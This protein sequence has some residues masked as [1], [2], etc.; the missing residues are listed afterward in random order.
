MSKQWIP[1]KQNGRDVRVQYSIPI[2]F[3]IG[4][5]KVF[6]TDL[7]NSPYGFVFEIDGTDYTIDEVK[8]IIGKS[9]PSE[10]IKAVETYYDTTKYAIGDKKAIYL[11]I[12]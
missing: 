1:G 11:V 6:L 3:N 2:D 9:F 7:R 8:P 4:K 12:L 5:K 10:R